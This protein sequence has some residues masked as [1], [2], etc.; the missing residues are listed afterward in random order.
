MNSGTKI[1]ASELFGGMETRRASLSGGEEK[2]RI[3]RLISHF[4][5]HYYNIR[6]SV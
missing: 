6:F 2:K 5:L 4:A 1:R 3:V